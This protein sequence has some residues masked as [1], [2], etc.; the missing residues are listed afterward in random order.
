MLLWKLEKEE[1]IKYQVRRRKETIKI[2]A[3]T[4]K[5]GNQWG[6]SKFFQNLFEKNKI[7]K[8]LTRLT[9]K[10]R[11]K[12]QISNIRYERGNITTDPI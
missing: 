2:R 12:T 8:P 1:Q 5:A 11:G 4:C 6:K 3:K 7:D 10:K 9:K